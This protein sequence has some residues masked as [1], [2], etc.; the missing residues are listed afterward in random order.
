MLL[1]EIVKRKKDK[2]TVVNATYTLDHVQS[3]VTVTVASSDDSFQKSCTAVNCF[4]EINGY[5]DRDHHTT[6]HP[7]KHLSVYY[8]APV[9]EMICTVDTP[10]T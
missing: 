4:I 9:L 2:D 5:N 3:Y 10:V 6:V 7:A 8:P 1:S